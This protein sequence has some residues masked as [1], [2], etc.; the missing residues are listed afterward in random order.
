MLFEKH[1]KTSDSVVRAMAQH[2]WN[3]P[4]CLSCENPKSRYSQCSQEDQSSVVQVCHIIRL[5]W[6]VWISQIP[7]LYLRISRE[8]AFESAFFYKCLSWALEA[9]KLGKRE[10]KPHLAGLLAPDLSW[11]GNFRWCV[12]TSVVILTEPYLEPIG[13]L[14]IVG[15]GDWDAC[16][17]KRAK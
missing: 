6:I 7:G 4:T 17:Y 2:R 15:V 14:C 5:S 16:L 8:G 3:T 12:E 10:R 13:H 1:F 9:G 11:W